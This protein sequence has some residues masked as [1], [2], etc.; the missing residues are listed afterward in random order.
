MKMMIISDVRSSSESIIPYGFNLAK[1]MQWEVDII[2]TID[3]KVHQGVYSSYSDSQ[4]ISPGSKLSHKDIIGREKRETEQILDK[5]LSKEASR[6]NYPLKIN[7]AVAIKSMDALMK[8]KMHSDAV[9]LL[10]VSSEADNHIFHSLHEILTMVKNSRVL[11]LL[12]PSG[13]SF[14]GINTVMIPVDFSSDNYQR[15]EKGNK[16]LEFFHP[17]INAVSVVKKRDFIGSKLKS[18]TWI[19]NARDYFSASNMDGNVLA[20]S[21]YSE[22]LSAYIQRTKPDLVLLSLIRNNLFRSFF[23]KGIDE[24]LIGKIRTPVL[25]LNQ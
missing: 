21:N 23:G 1:N 7:T 6:L 18:K 4:T 9:S 11:S 2:H 17:E 24:I 5:I 13:Y 20:G 10:V 15:F 12:V 3:P 14:S 8:E 16:L 19:T 22:I 25:I